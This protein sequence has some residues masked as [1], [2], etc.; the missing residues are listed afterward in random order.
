MPDRAV[1]ELVRVEVQ[2]EPQTSGDF[3]TETLWAEYL[4]HNRY[5]VRNSPFFAFGISNEDIILCTESQGHPKFQRVLIRGNHS[6]YRIRLN[7]VSIGDG[8]FQEH[9]MPLEAI[10]CSFE[11]GP[12]LS[13]DVPPETD[14]NATYA[15][16]EAGER[17][18]V[19]EFDEGHCGH[20]P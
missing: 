20:A 11:E 17:A 13:V 10:G 19:W 7:D 6:T 9:W 12:V 2:L 3:A 15:L 5:R 1:G 8:I 4:G 18:G 16:L 14:I